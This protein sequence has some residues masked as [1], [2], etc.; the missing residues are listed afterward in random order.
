[1]TINMLL[2]P[3]RIS[4][5]QPRTI[6]RVSPPSSCMPPILSLITCHNSSLPGLRRSFRRQ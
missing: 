4:S 5:F 2:R 1:M 6:L 3:A